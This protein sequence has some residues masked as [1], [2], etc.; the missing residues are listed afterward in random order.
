MIIIRWSPMSRRNIEDI[1]DY[2][3]ERDASAARWVIHLIRERAKL[4]KEFP[5]LAPCIDATVLHKV[6]I[7]GLQYVLL[8][9]H[10]DGV[11]EIL[12]V[13][14]TAQDWRG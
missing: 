13:H 11:V 1:R 4:L 14:H 10:R 7:T 3:V 5:E 12:R 2:P 9:R 8:Y 6:S